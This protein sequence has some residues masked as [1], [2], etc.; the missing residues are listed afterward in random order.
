MADWDRIGSGWGRERGTGSRFR[1]LDISSPFDR[2]ERRFY[3]KIADISWPFVLLLMTIAGYGLLMLYSAANGHMDPWAGR[4]LGRFG[5]GLSFFLVVSLIDVRA[6]MRF[7]YGLYGIA[8]ALLVLVEVKGTVGMGAQR[9]IDVGFVQLQP[10]EVMKIAIVLTLARYFHKASAHDM[11]RI[12]F[13][14]PPIALV[15][16][17]VGLVL[18]QPDLGTAMMLLMASAVMFLLAGMR[19]WVFAVAIIAAAGAAPVAWPFLHDFQKNRIR[20][21]LNPERDPQGAGYHITQSKIALG[22]GGLTGKGFM[23]GTQSHLSFLPERQTDFI[24]TMLGEEFGMIGGLVLIGLYSLV[25]V[26][27]F[28]IALRCPHQFGR[29]AALGITSTFFLYVFIN[30]AMVTGLIPVVGVP[31]PMISYGGTAMLTLMVGF[32]ILM[33]IHIHRDVAVNRRGGWEEE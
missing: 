18:K 19:L 20:T 21:F 12:T 16:L 11:G 9:W 6:L 4:Q 25:V 22:S 8:I 15:L 17:P 29:L 2:G 28:V 5:L 27:G 13:L 33:S 31:L 24:F 7:A 10:S 23:L 14:L 26:Y 1:K 30:I 3:E 32:G